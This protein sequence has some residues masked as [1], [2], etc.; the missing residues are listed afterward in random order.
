MDYDPII[1]VPIR[2]KITILTTLPASPYVYL[3]P[4]SYEVE[5][6]V[7]SKQIWHVKLYV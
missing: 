4:C 1:D 5:H 6:P 2:F 3:L 7:G